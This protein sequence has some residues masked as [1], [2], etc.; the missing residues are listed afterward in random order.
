MDSLNKLFSNNKVKVLGGDV[1]SGEW[2][3][4]MGT[5]W[6]AFEQID[7]RT[8]VKSVQP[9][10]EE[11][12]KKLPEA[13]AWGLAGLTLGPLGLLAGV[14]FGGNKKAVCALIE[15]DDDRKF[16]AVM[17]SK[18]YQEVLGHSITNRK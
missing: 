3:Y 15:L 16:L 14:V 1:A 9:Q 8:Q 18:I 7:L 12:V 2:E 13:I 10:T 11:S 17:D 5:L 6:G 4:S